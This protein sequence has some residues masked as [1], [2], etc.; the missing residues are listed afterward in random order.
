MI[1]SN[2]TLILAALIASL[3]ATINVN[4]GTVHYRWMDD[5]G[6]PVHSDRAPPKGVDYEVITTGSSLKR[7]VSANEG[8]VPAEV[9]PRVGNEFNQVDTDDAARSEK[10]QELCKRAMQN[11]EALNGDAQVRMTDEQGEE[12]YLSDEEVFIER[13][14]AKAQ[15]SVY[16]P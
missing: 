14:K 11:L 12:R 15:K 16:C 7:V 5:R 1:N 2:E 6:N 3:V 9:K 10:N 8:A 13:E 4:A